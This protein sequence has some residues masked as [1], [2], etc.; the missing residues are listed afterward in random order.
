VGTLLLLVTAVSLA[1]GEARAQVRGMVSRRTAFAFGPTGQFMATTTRMRGFTDATSCSPSREFIS[2]TQ[3]FGANYLSAYPYPA[4][5][6]GYLGSGYYPG[7]YEA[8]LVESD[9]RYLVDRQRAGLAREAVQQSKLVTQRRAFDEYLYERSAAP[10]WEDDRDKLQAMT[11]RRSRN[12]PPVNEIVSGRSLNALLDHLQQ[13]EAAGTTASDL[14]LDEDVVARINVTS[15]RGGHLGLV[16]EGGRL[17]W[18]L[19]LT[20]EGLREERQQLDSLL[21]E[22]LA[23]VTS[24]PVE[25]DALAQMQRLSDRLQRNLGARARNLPPG[26][27][28]EARQFLTDIDEAIKALQHPDAGAYLTRKLSPHGQTVRELV[29]S[30]TRQGLRFAPAV[31]GDEPA[32]L[33]LHRALVRYDSSAAVSQR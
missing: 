20:D 8:D 23:T 22:A 17:H 6:P 12:E 2:R 9:S 27:Y 13:L 30:M 25:R 32:Y 3:T 5:Y 1:A 29:R 7:P 18:P 26:Q 10:T 28:V 14:P 16:K 31:R 33:A 4:Y 24:R 15:G 19:A 11:L 21:S